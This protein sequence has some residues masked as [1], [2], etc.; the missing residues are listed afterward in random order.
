MDTSKVIQPVELCIYDLLN[1]CS[2]D[3]CKLVHLS[4][5]VYKKFC[6]LLDNSLLK[7]DEYSFTIGEDVFSCS[8]IGGYLEEVNSGILS[9]IFVL[10]LYLYLVE[11]NY[12]KVIEYCL[13]GVGNNDAKLINLLGSYYYEIEKFY[14]K[15]IEYYSM[16]ANLN[17]ES[18]IVNLGVYYYYIEKNYEKAVEYYNIAATTFGNTRAIVNLG[19]YY[20]FKLKDYKKCIE[21]YLMA[22]DR[23]SN[24]AMFELAQYYFN[25]ENSEMGIKYCEMAIENETAEQVYRLENY[26][27][28][29]QR[30]SKVAARRLGNYYFAL[31]DYSVAIKYY[32]IAAENFDCISMEKLA[33]YYETIEKNKEKEIEY[34]T[35][36][37]A[38]GSS[39]AVTSLIVYY[40]SIQNSEKML[41]YL[42][43]GLK[44]KDSWAIANLG[45]YYNSI[46]PD[47]DKSIYYY[48]MAVDHGYYEA[49]DRLGYHYYNL[50][51]FVDAVRYYEIGVNGGCH[52]AMNSLGHYYST[53]LSDYKRATK[54]Y[55]IA[56]KE[57]CYTRW[58]TFVDSVRKSYE[59]N[60]FV[61]ACLLAKKEQLII[62]LSN[63]QLFVLK[64]KTIMRLLKHLARNTNDECLSL[65]L[66]ST[67]IRKKTQILI[68]HFKYHPDSSTFVM[69]KE[70]FENASQNILNKL[71]DGNSINEPEKCNTN[72]QDVFV[73]NPVLIKTN[74]DKINELIAE[75]N[76]KKLLV[77]LSGRL[78]SVCLGLRH[79]SQACFN[80]LGNYFNRTCS[81][82]II[83]KMIYYTE[84]EE[85][86][87]NEIDVKYSLW[88]PD[89]C[90]QA[91]NDFYLNISRKIIESVVE[92]D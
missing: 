9:N 53:I 46:V 1:K 92:K 7:V 73:T 17:N 63:K 50:G 83:S 20:D 11:K 79:I 84:N 56:I 64:E 2:N 87:L 59:F 67:V 72:G 40:N 30:G 32:L 42:L 54:Y 91:I 89:I 77:F 15:S 12:K 38:C 29:I 34:H 81:D 19:T 27:R 71:V 61:N 57:G 25:I 5:V 76:T 43:I 3:N 33:V 44:N 47:V 68:E 80:D 13:I 37:A 78:G 36:A 70:H 4:H 35:K 10:C 14:A 74:D 16:A 86:D 24:Y 31:Q 52:Y 48:K 49:A 88:T 26:M 69:L 51:N 28:N 55:Y 58:D 65:A 90:D 62:D 6:H 41:E 82:S 85:I 60:K 8:C 23:G 66:V 45:Y 18:A 22:I 75:K 39:K 21:Y